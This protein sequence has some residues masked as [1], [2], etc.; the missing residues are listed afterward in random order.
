MV[1]PPAR[2]LVLGGLARRAS[3]PLLAVLPSEREAEE[4]ADDVSLF[5][6]DVSFLPAWE[7]LPFEHVSPNASTMARRAEARHRL[8]Q[9]GPGG[10]VVGSVR[11]PVPWNATTTGQ[12]AGVVGT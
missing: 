12:G 7:T 6:D 11:S 8:Q 5:L 9:A 4:L 1:P 3:G 10:V 2:S